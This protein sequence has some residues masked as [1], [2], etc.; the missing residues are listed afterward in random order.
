MVEIEPIQN[1][2][3]PYKDNQDWH[4]IRASL[5]KWARVFD[6]QDKWVLEIGS[7]TGLLQDIARKYVGID[8]AEKAALYM[9][10]PFCVAS[11]EA[12]PF[13]DSAFE[14]VFSIWV[15]EHVRRPE[16]M[17]AEM[18][19]VAANEG[20][21]FLS[22]A[23]GIGNWVSSGVAV[24]PIS[25]LS[26]KEILVRTLLPIWNSILL[27]AVI[28]LPKRLIKLLAFA[29]TR[30]PTKLSYG[31]LDPNYDEFLTND[32]DAWTSLD[33]FDTYLYFHSRGDLCVTVQNPIA[34]LTLRSR[35]QVF[36]V[37]KNDK[38][39]EGSN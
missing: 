7:G 2:E 35:P 29:I 4:H 27:R 5:K 17:L 24:R 3:H 37:K 30:K 18:R 16:R 6:A 26:L 22:A 23:Y 21:V 36:I 34:G 39:D 28:R 9:E 33:P 15:L 10:K 20:E 11:A 19:R 8:F 32:S 14:G 12:L 13:A 31:V 25:A 38:I 1:E